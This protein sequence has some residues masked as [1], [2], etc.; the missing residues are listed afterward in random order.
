MCL[1]YINTFSWLAVLSIGMFVWCIY[2]KSF[3]D[4]C[5]FLKSVLDIRYN[6]SSVA[7]SDTISDAV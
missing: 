1:V 4:T 2:F 7:V 6:K 5:Y 3:K